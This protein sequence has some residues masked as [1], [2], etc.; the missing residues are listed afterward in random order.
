MIINMNS[1]ISYYLFIVFSYCFY[2]KRFVSQVFMF[3]DKNF[4]FYFFHIE[5][6]ILCISLSIRLNIYYR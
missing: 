2:L 1:I 6:M 4:I 5:F 3:V